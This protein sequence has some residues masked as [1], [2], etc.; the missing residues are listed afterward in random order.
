[1]NSTP[2]SVKT[3]TATL[4]GGCFWCL[5]AAYRMLEGVIN[6][7]S[8]YTGGNTTNPTYEQVT[9]GSTHHTES[10][11]IVFDPEIISYGEILDVFWVIHDPTSLNRQGNDVGTQYRSAIFYADEKQKLTAETAIRNITPLWPNPI[12]TELLE[13]KE[14][15]PAEDYHQDYF[16]KNPGQGYCQA[17]INPKLTKLREHFKSKLK[18]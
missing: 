1:M 16:A 10:V 4:A 12:V 6:V 5:D 13:L 3:E 8:G 2:S 9:S 7:T 15:Y 11:S 18:K 14:F 17:V